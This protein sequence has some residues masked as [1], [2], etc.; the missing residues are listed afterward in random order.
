DTNNSTNMPNDSLEESLEDLQK[1]LKITRELIQ[2]KE[3]NVPSFNNL[4]AMILSGQLDIIVFLDYISTMLGGD[5]GIDGQLDIMISVWMM[6]KM[7]NSDASHEM[8]DDL[9]KLII[10]EL[11]Y[12]LARVLEP[13][14]LTNIGSLHIEQGDFEQALKFLKEAEISFDDA[15]PK[16]SEFL[17]LM[18]NPLIHTAQGTIQ[19]NL[20]LLAYIQGNNEASIAHY[21]KSLDLLWHTA[22]HPYAAMDTLLSLGIAED[23]L[24]NST[25]ALQHYEDAIHI[26]ETVRQ[27]VNSGARNTGH[28]NIAMLDSV[29][30]QDPLNRHV[31]LYNQAICHYTNQDRFEEA[32][33][34]A[35]RSRA[36]LFL[37]MIATN[38]EHLPTET[39]TLLRELQNIFNLLHG[40]EMELKQLEIIGNHDY[41][42]RLQ[43]SILESGRQTL[44]NDYRQKLAQLQ[45]I[46]PELA[47][48]V[49]KPMS[50]LDF[51]QEAKSRIAHI[52]TEILDNETT[53]I[54]YQVLE[55]RLLAWVIDR[56]NFTTVEPELPRT[57]LNRQIEF[58]R[59]L[60]SEREASTKE[61]A[62]LYEHLIAPLKPYIQH[63]NL[64]IV[65][66]NQLHYLPFA[67][68]WDADNEQYLLEQYTI[69]YAPSASTL[70]HLIDKQNPND[71]RFLVMGA[72]DS[73]LKYA[74]TEIS[75]VSMLMGTTP[76]T[77]TTASESKLHTIVKD[78]DIVHLAAHGT[79]SETNPLASHIQLAPDGNPATRN[80]ATTTSDGLLEVREV[81]GLPL[82]EA[83]LVVLSA[84]ETAIGERGM[85]D[86]IVGLTRSFLY[87]GTPAII[88]TLW[89]ISDEA[90]SVLMT[91]FYRN[92][93]E[94]EMNTAEALRAA[95]L[96]VMQ[97]VDHPQWAS[98]YYW[99]AFGLTGDYR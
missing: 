98:P 34:M 71:G 49:A 73:S 37:D 79:Y 1:A 87:A 19:N 59:N 42:Y 85:G 97:D 51:A 62:N 89:N 5:Q 99:A 61:L 77:G 84:C 95:Q 88:T 52:Q 72:P 10:K 30:L 47:E 96:S 74:G 69:S 56:D 92:L 39:A 50:D 4:L 41:V 8:A 18:L 82:S 91:E 13:I 53:L 3:E 21:E 6:L 25:Q 23:E 66:H 58:L 93:I 81:F 36:R 75:N 28:D 29:A 11:T 68:L 60:I 22:G 38:T 54:E 14:L 70:K 48:L 76:F 9:L 67:A 55:D 80:L 86:E 2:E 94:H 46:N 90:S 44:E 64:I 57:E 20:G 31:L 63:T 78:F 17:R 26:L 7:N 40:N 16:N 27:I 83:N 32:F 65:P 45:E 12:A 24:E 33:E 15:T 35:E 43:K